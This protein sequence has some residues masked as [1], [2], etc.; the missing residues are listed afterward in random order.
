MIDR[1]LSNNFNM[2]SL[3]ILIILVF[4]ANAQLAQSA[5]TGKALKILKDDGSITYI[6]TSAVDKITFE[7]PLA[8]GDTHEGGIIFYLDASGEHGLVAASS[9]QSSGIQ[10]SGGT[11][12]TLATGDGVGAG[13]ENTYMIVAIENLTPAGFG[14]YAAKI[15]SDL[16]I[17]G[18]T[19]WYLPSKHELNLMYTNLQQASPTPL[20]GFASDSYWSSTE[21]IIQTGYA[22]RQYLI[23]GYQ[24]YSAKNVPTYNVRAIRKF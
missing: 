19:D 1:H 2:N 16:T 17:G 21:H 20:G 23:S 13:E 14:S 12:R 15:C 22:W 8:I 4:S 7:T 3:Y 9:D 24:Q 11:T 5:H 10:W 6:N 18:Y